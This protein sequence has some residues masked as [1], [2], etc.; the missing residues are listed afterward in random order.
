MNQSTVSV[1]GQA[2][3]PQAIREELGIVP[4]TKLAWSTHNGVIIVVP[5]PRDPVRASFGILAEGGF[6]LDEFLK[7]RRK[8]RELDK[9]RE[10]RLDRQVRKA[11]RKRRT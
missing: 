10:A 7:E 6:T 9:R 1:R 5:I 2:V 8:E 4:N 3:I 11:R